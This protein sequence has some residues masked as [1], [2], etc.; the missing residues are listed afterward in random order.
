MAIRYLVDTNVWSESFRKTPDAGVLEWLAKHEDE[1][2]ISVVVVGEMQHGIFALED[3]EKKKAL[4]K[5]TKGIYEEVHCYAWD[6]KT[7]LIWGEFGGEGQR[8]KPPIKFS[9]RDSFIAATALRHNLTLVTRNVKDF[10]NVPELKI[11]N[12]FEKA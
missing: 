2:S 7:A 1:L 8:K 9:V 11:F 5:L 10:K 12:P 6:L 3:G 4:Q